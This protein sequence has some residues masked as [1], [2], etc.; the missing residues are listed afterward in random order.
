MKLNE[1]LQRLADSQYN[2]VL[3]SI[4]KDLDAGKIGQ[5]QA[6]FLRLWAKEAIR[7]ACAKRL[8]REED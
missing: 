7:M 1:E 5:E 6:E 8:L 4:Q 3:T 2:I